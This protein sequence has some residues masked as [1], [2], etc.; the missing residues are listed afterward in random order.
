MLILANNENPFVLRELFHIR[1]TQLTLVNFG[2][3]D[4]ESIEILSFMDVP[5]LKK[6]FICTWRNI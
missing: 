4:V 6:I 5:L 2:G 3:N 1:L